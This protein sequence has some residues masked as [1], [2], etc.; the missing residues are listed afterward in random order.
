[1]QASIFKKSYYGD[2]E[3]EKNAEIGMKHALER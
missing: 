3:K 1:L 2:Q